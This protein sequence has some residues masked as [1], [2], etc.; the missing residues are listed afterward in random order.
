[1]S[2]RPSI[3]PSQLLNLALPLPVHVQLSAH[4]YSPL[5]GRVPHGAYSRF[6][7][8]LIRDYFSSHTLDLAPYTQATPGSWLVRGSPEAVAA[9]SALLTKES[10]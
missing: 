6:L 8:D 10:T 4:L 5:E 1:M 3:I 9:L 7:S 2:R